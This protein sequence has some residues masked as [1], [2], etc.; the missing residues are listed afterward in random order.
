MFL[1]DFLFYGAGHIL[2]VS[3]KSGAKA[4]TKYNNHSPDSATL[5]VISLS[6][7]LLYRATPVNGKHRTNPTTRA[8][9]SSSPY[10]FALKGK[11][12]SLKTILPVR[13]SFYK[14][15]I[16]ITQIQISE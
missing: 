5:T 12:P 2:Q 13:P 14:A 6:I 16:Q 8:G 4:E 15:F 11:L 3:C 9:N 10:A 1:P 7:T